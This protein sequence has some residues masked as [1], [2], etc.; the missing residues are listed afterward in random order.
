[1]D[2][3]RQPISNDTHGYYQGLKVPFF[4]SQAHAWLFEKETTL[5][6]APKHGQ[7]N[8]ISDNTPF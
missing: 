5:Q 7:K 2:Y 6:P 8:T 1:M 4:E 3:L